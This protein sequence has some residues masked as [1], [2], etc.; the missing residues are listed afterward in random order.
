MSVCVQPCPI[1]DRPA[2]ARMLA[3]DGEEEDQDRV[4]TDSPE[5]PRQAVPFLFGE[6]ELWPGRVVCRGTNAT[7]CRVGRECSPHSVDVS[8]MVMRI[9]EDTDRA[10]AYLRGWSLAY[11]DLPPDPR[12]MRPLAISTC[13]R[14]VLLHRYPGDLFDVLHGD[15]GRGCTLFRPLRA[16][17]DIAE[18]VLLMHAR[19]LAHRDIKPENVMVTA[20]G[21]VVLGDLDFVVRARFLPLSRFS[22]TSAY[23]PPHVRTA[24]AACRQEP[25]PGLAHLRDPGRIIYDAF[26]VDAFAAAATILDVLT[27]CSHEDAAQCAKGVRMLGGALEDAMRVALHAPCDEALSRLADRLREQL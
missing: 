22:G 24:V 7:V 2:R 25:R 19:G 10:G 1:S 18:A 13:G 5:T 12:I 8:A 15:K 27:R 26:E 4:A 23:L 3:F 6:S 20:A 9:Y 11:R 21:G 14:A 17:V 16:A